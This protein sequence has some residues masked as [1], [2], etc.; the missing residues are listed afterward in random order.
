MVDRQP[1]L[2]ESEEVNSQP[3]VDAQGEDDEKR[4]VGNLPNFRR[5]HS[6]IFGDSGFPHEEECQYRPGEKERYDELGGLETVRRS[7]SQTKDEEDNSDEHRERSDQVQ[8]LPFSLGVGHNPT[9]FRDE[10]E[11]GDGKGDDEDVQDSEEPSPG[12]TLTLGGDV[13]DEA[14]NEDSSDV[15]EG[16]GHAIN[17]QCLAKLVRL[18]DRDDQTIG[19]GDERRSS[20]SRNRTEDEK[21]ESVGEEG[22]DQIE[23]SEG[24]KAVCKDRLGRVEVGYSAPEQ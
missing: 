24:Q 6:I 14:G 10:S 16:A 4:R 23:D 22:N 15:G 9:G 13:L 19:S 11:R 1:S 3:A 5:D 7:K 17:R 2:D 20:D 12:L 21:A 18:E 8:A